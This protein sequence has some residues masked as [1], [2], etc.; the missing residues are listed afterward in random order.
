MKKFWRRTKP[1]K[2]DDVVTKTA[3]Q[4]VDP[5]IAETL[6]RPEN[7]GV[8]FPPSHR[9]ERIEREDWNR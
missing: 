4:Q 7:F 9:F 8:A 6:S 1:V 5:I 2:T 3:P